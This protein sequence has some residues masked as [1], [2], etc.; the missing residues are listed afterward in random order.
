MPDKLGV[1]FTFEGP[2]F[3]PNLP[4]EIYQLFN[5]GL[6]ELATIEGANRVKN[7]LYGPPAHLYSQ[8]T[9]A[10]RHGAHTRVLR[11]GV[12]ATVQSDNVIVVDAG[13]G[14]YGADVQ[15]APKVEKLYGMYKKTH[16]YLEAN[17]D[18]L[19]EKYIMPD[20]L[21]VMQ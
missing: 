16:Q 17:K 2:L 6:Q 11:R 10:E 19:T 18:S 9:K 7:Q 13:E 12:G 5:H 14:F 20:V 1:G 8:S 21:K 4:S 3:N 15:Y